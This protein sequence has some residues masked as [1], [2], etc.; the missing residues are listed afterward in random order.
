MFKSQVIEQIAKLQLKWFKAFP[1]QIK[2]LKYSSVTNFDFDFSQAS[3]IL[4]REIIQ[5]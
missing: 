5:K 4:F 1:V 3:C 2:F